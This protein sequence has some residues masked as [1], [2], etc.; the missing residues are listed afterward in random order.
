MYS[1][2]RQLGPFSL[3]V[4]MKGT[5]FLKGHYKFQSLKQTGMTFIHFFSS[6]NLPARK[7]RLSLVVI[8]LCCL[9]VLQSCV[10][11]RFF[12]N[13]AEDYISWEVDRFL[14]LTSEQEDDVDEQLA[15]IIN[16]HRRDEIPKYIA[17]LRE[18]KSRLGRDINPSDIDWFLTTIDT[19]YINLSHLFADAATDLLIS[20]SPSQIKHLE[21][22]L[23]E[24]N[25]EW[26]EEL[27]ERSEAPPEERLDQI[28]ETIEEWLGSVTEIQQQKIRELYKKRTDSSQIRYQFRL[29]RQSRFL[30]II[31][32]STSKTL[33][34]ATLLD[35][36]RNPEADYPDK[37]KHF[38]HLWRSRLYSLVDLL[39]ETDTP[40]QRSYLINEV[41]DYL[42][43]L[44]KLK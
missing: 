4:N 43:Q 13:L 8:F 6:T 18:T 32:T 40:K 38:N 30:T 26:L 36:V 3:E 14:D 37:Y 17:F 2:L 10:S 24:D 31:K 7:E 28:Y 35:W 11:I 9:L 39:E 33:M 20:L 27:K 21:A 22:E 15:L 12:Y 23:I 1:K 41:D 29:N 5:M 34:K 44:Q 42:S 25:K 16:K 19:F